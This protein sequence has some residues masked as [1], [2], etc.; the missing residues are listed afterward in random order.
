MTSP[1][2]ANSRRET[3][4]DKDFATKSGPIASKQSQSV[5]IARKKK[6]QRLRQIRRVDKA[7]ALT[8]RLEKKKSERKRTE[9]VQSPRMDSELKEKTLQAHQVGN[10]T[11]DPDHQVNRVVSSRTANQSNRKDFVRSTRQLTLSSLKA[12]IHCRT[13][14]SRLLQL[15]D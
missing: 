2:S 1:I 6:N 7:I 9:R 14:L 10:Q 12:P 13:L 11:H 5:R 4:S 15:D 3:L 8:P